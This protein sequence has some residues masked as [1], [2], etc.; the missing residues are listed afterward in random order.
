MKVCKGLNVHSDL[1][2]GP[3]R[4]AKKYTDVGDDGG[5]GDEKTGLEYVF[6]YG[7]TL[8]TIHPAFPLLGS[9]PVSYPTERPVLGGYIDRN[10]GGKLLVCG[11]LRMFDD[12]FITCDDNSKVLNGI[13]RFL[14]D[15]DIDLTDINRKEDNDTT[16]YHRVPDI[17]ALSTNVKS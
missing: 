5:M 9:G 2:G 12:E 17:A 3:G 11:S 4:Y 8:N 13:M 7:A 15:S 6:P 10:K 16:E 14:G 1:N